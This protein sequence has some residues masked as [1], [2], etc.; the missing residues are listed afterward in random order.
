MRSRLLSVIVSAEKKTY[1]ST[2][3]CNAYFIFKI[4]V[5]SKITTVA[6]RLFSSVK[7]ELSTWGKQVMQNNGTRRKYTALLFHSANEKT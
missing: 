1:T 6:A 4:N 3:I 5:L 7:A 2:L